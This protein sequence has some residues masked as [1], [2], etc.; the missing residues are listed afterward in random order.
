MAY[1][2]PKQRLNPF[3]G[4]DWE[5]ITSQLQGNRRNQALALWQWCAPRY[6]SLGTAQARYFERYGAAATYV[7]IDKVRQWA[8]LAPYGD[9]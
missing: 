6:S 3:L 9:R 8:G 4:M 7:R 1:Q 5:Q 2:E